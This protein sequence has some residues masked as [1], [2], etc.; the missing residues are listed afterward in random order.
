MPSDAGS[1]TAFTGNIAAFNEG[2]ES[3][4]SSNK[5]ALSKKIRNNIE[6]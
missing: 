4:K 6:K 3:I 5:D 1:S 2:Y